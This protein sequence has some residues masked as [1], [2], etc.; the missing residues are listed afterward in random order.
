MTDQKL[1][2]EELRAKLEE[3]R[4]ANKSTMTAL[5]QELGVSSTR[6]NK[7]LTGKPEGNVEEL[8]TRIADMLKSASSRTHT[9]I[10]P[11]ETSAT[12]IIRAVFELARKT[13]DVAL[14]VGP[15]GIGK[16]VAKDLYCA[17]HPTTLG[18][19]VPRWLRHEGGVASL[20]FGACDTRNWD[21]HTARSE[22]MTRRLRGS[23]RLVIIDNAQ[24]MTA[25]AREWLFD[26]HDET[27]CPIALIGNPEVLQA[28]RR[29]DQHFS[30]IGM[31]QEVA[32]SPKTVKDY[33]AAMVDALVKKPDD[34]LY[35]LATAVARERG[36]LRALRKQ[37]LLMLD[38][39]ESKP[40]EGD[41]IRAFHAAHSK[42]VRD[43]QL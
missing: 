26:F 18:I 21:G 43:Y 1:Y 27:D 38:L 3:Y 40:F 42:L 35:A 36:H 4:Q 20:L 6:V 41:Q 32:L 13:N 37:L 19:S 15:A 28:I 11:F 8:E 10:E 14:I 30:R 7:Y 5:G 24:R 39:C 16:T 12:E 29:C 33:A 22:Y 9:N 31:Y 25:G 2:S 34:G 23:N 17:E